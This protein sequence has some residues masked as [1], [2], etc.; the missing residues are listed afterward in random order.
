MPDICITSSLQSLPLQ[1]P[2]PSDLLVPSDEVLLF[3][4]RHEFVVDDSPVGEEECAPRT[5]GV[6]EEELLRQPH[7]AVVPL[8]RLLEHVE[9]LL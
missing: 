1:P 6:E 5:E 4:K 3:E 7:G 8:P 9:V 2:P